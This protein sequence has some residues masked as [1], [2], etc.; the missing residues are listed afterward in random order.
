MALQDII[1]TIKEE[2]ER[3][4]KE[5]SQAKE[6]KLF[7]LKE[8]YG[9]EAEERKENLLK[10]ARQELEKEIS[11]TAWKARE[12]RKTSVLKKKRE[13]IE[14]LY[15]AA[16]EEISDLDREKYK[17]FLNKSLDEALLE[18]GREGIKPTEL[19]VFSAPETKTLLEEILRKKQG[20]KLSDEHLNSRGGFVLKSVGIN[21]D[22]TLETIFRKTREKTELAVANSLFGRKN[23]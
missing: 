20:L 23:I 7:V 13:I 11:E 8:K 22:C 10:G 17:E 6:K 12:K 4:K 14:N 21:I 15:N 2:G 1:E 3:K 19:E 5:I 9:K 16:L 18:A